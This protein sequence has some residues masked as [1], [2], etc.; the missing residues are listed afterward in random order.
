ME[1]KD[2]D[3]VQGGESG[4]NG[5]SSESGDGSLVLDDEDVASGWTPVI[6]KGEEWELGWK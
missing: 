5:E 1:M 2:A 4:K 6:W 3:D